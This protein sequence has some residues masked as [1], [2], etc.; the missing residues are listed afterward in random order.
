M[1]IGF[2]GHQKID[3]PDRWGWVQEQFLRV[4]REVARPCDRVA[5]SLAIGGDQIFSEMAL[6]EGLAL[7]VVVPC[8][9]YEGTF[10]DP[11]GL[12][13]YRALLG[14]AVEVTTLEFPTPSEEAFLAAGLSI[15]DRCGRLV[16]LWN[17]KKAAGKGGTGDIVAYAL[18]RK[19]PVIHI[20]PD[21]M[22]VSG[23]PA[24]DQEEAR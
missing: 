17:G 1:I 21:Q 5:S 22:Q 11:K 23:L 20:N 6:A 14:Q 13:Q 10:H 15:V 19:L 7:E 9:G 8:I 24:G 12:L 3:H 4:L 2:T 18:E 16:S